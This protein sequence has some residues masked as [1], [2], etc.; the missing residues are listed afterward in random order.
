MKKLFTL[1]AIL[2]AISTYSQEM[3]VHKTDGNVE[4]FLLSTIDSITFTISQGVNVPCPGIPTVLYEGK[5]YN[6]V[7]IGTQCW[8]K[9]NLNVGIK[10]NGVNDQTNNS[11]I[12]KYCFNNLES[13][14][15]IYGGTYQWAEMVQ[16]LNGATNT[17]S[18]NPVPTGN[19]Q[20]ICPYGWHIPTDPEWTVLT[21]FL[22]G[23]SVAGGKIKEIELA[24]WASPNTGATNSSGFTALPGGNRQN[25]G[26][27][28]GLNSDGDFWS[29]T[30]GSN[31]GAWARY[32]YYNF[33]YVNRDQY[34]KEGGFSVRCVKD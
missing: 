20:G 2:L 34:Y 11:V 27:Y 19:V 21:T 31:I 15:D 18:W 7:Q 23:E 10:I 25:S 14:C 13:N 26:S 32:L 24:H 29:L 8:L 17:T 28:F 16:Y 33:E 30:E 12:E 3:K 5:T 9:E 6:T 4:S 22:G 1:I